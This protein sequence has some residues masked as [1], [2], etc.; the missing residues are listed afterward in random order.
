MRSYSHLLARLAGLCSAALTIAF[1]AGCSDDPSPPTVDEMA[2]PRPVF[3]LGFDGLDPGLVQEMEEGGL[4]PNF[5]RLREEG[6]VG[7]VRS[8]I[9]MISPP[10][11]TTVATGNR[12]A[13]HGIWSFWIQDGEDPR[14]RYVDATCRLS[15]A[16]WEDLTARGRD[17]GVINVPVTSPPDSVQGFMIAGFPY[18]EGAPLTFPAELETEIV[19]AGYRRD[20]FN[21]P[22]AI[23]QEEEWLD[24]ML[25]IGKARRRI[26]LDLLFDRRPDLSFIV[27]TTPDRIQHHLW[28][29][30]D[31]DHPH[32]P[33]EAPE[34][35]ETAIR[36]SYVWCDG[37]LG[38]VLDRIDPGALLIVLSDHGFGPAYLGVS[39]NAALEM[40]PATLRAQG[41]T[42]RNLFGGDFYLTGDAT[43]EYREEF[44]TALQQLTDSDG[45]PLVRAVHDTRIPDP[46]GY[47]IG[48][49][50]DFV[51]EEAEGFLFV[52]GPADGPLV[53]VLPVTGFSGYHRREGYFGAYGPPIVRGPVRTL[54]LRD[55]TAITMHV[56]G[57]RIPRRYVHNI[58]KKLFPLTYFVER[59]MAFSGR[60]ET[61]LRRP[62]EV[63]GE[64]AAG[65]EEQLRALGYVR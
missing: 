49:G 54:D 59:P 4:L 65:L 26:G 39:K 58:P 48:L 40:L 51:A 46:L 17:V 23:G 15:P 31:P 61:E 50:P 47:G 7:E 6:A 20:A 64:A 18:P 19:D 9:P 32:H 33:P 2:Q 3:L 16:L 36:D 53:G 13:E 63:R 55:V 27:F 5:T 43:P 45:R 24:E 37:I 1:V 56:L 57:E 38:E 8:T 52:P 42:S 30:H 60:P 41:V 12:P 14:G 11:W 28:R 10:A 25:E 29:F 44:R 62:G 22:P 35:L 21:G 34:R